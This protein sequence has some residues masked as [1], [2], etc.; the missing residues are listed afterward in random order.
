VLHG[1]EDVI[2]RGAVMLPVFER[3]FFGIQ[4]NGAACKKQV[5]RCAQDDNFV[6]GKS[7]GRKVEGE[8]RWEKWRGEVEAKSV[9]EKL[10]GEVEGKNKLT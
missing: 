7:R 8:S 3:Q 9:G 6:E 4:V 2:K 10:R 5:L 1:K